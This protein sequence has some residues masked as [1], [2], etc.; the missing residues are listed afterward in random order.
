MLHGGMTPVVEE[1][2][3]HELFPGFYRLRHTGDEIL[4]AGGLD[5]SMEMAL[6]D[7]LDA[8]AQHREPVSNLQT[9]RASLALIEAVRARQ[10]RAGA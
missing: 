2:V 8:F 10:G 5:G 7:L 3:E 4:G 6:D 9:A 1:R